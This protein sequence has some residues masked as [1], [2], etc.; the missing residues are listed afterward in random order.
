MQICNL[1]DLGWSNYFQSQ[2]DLESLGS[3]LPFRVVSIQRNLVE[4]VGFDRDNL[5][6][7][8]NISTYHWRDE[9]PEGHPSVGDWVM[10]DLEYQ[11]LHLLKRKSLIKRKSVGRESS[12]QPIA[13]NIDTAFIVTSCN[14]EFSV[15]RIERYLSIAAESDVHCVVVLTKIDQ[16]VDTQPYL[17]A[18]AQCD[19]ALNV[20]CVNATD[21]ASL[22]ILRSWIRP[23]QT[24]ALLGSS[25]VG[26]S[27]I[28][29]G[30]K[31]SLDQ[32]TGAIRESDSKGRHTTTS[33]SLH[34]LPGGG[35]LLDNPG[36]RELQIVDSE[37][38]IKA[39]FSDIDAL[40]KRCRF[41]DC[42]H[43]T[44]PGCA[45]VAAIKSGQLEQRRLDN[46]HSLLSEEARNS[47]SLAEQRHSDRALG[48]FY[49]TAQKTSRQFKS[50]D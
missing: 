29:N 17:D 26:K 20:E 49:K 31:G 22:G 46:Y 47:Q 11:P 12:I 42:Q 4:C 3:Q 28:I 36:M 24:V 23:G 16:C 35:L 2:L 48:R 7:E 33:R 45:V 10:L 18:I 32:E 37:E 50:R 15:N 1:L 25:G 41:R 27:T 43:T 39:T 38:G 6:K 9:P 30:L 19:P 34:C 14:D 44:E 13:S 5:V 40:A 8:L 21:S